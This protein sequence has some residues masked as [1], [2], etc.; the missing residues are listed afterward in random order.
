M[1]MPQAS[2]NSAQSITSRLPAVK[3]SLIWIAAIAF[4]VLGIFVYGHGWQKELLYVIGFLLG[5]AL[6]HA[7]FG[8]TSSFRQLLSVGQGQGL[9][10]HMLMLAI[11]S[12]FF[13]LIFSTGTTLTGVAPE[14]NVEPI[15]V[16]LIF[17]SFLFGIGMQLGG[18]CGL[19]LPLSGR[20]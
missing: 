17:G 6:Y 2:L 7:R 5:V 3:V 9:R 10:A 20:R 4:V 19:G 16:S 12:V 11:A 1:A 15:G 13:A 8:F 14:G 18:A